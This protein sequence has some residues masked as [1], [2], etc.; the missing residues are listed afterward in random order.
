LHCSRIILFVIVEL[1]WN[2]YPSTS[3]S[4][5]LLLF[6]HL[7]ILFGLWSSPAEYPY[8]DK[9]EKADRDSKESG[10]AM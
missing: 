3:Y 5:L 1:C 10:K 9:K 7:F 4:S 6:A 8:A 2:V